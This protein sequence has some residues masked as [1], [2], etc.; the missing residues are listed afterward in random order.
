MLANLGLGVLIP[1]AS[2]KHPY[3]AEMLVRAAKS[4]GQYSPRSG[5][6]NLGG[7]GIGTS[8]GPAVESMPQ[9][10]VYPYISRGIIKKNGISW[11]G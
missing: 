4:F 8:R 11:R 9:S 1:M 7:E 5:M 2:T 6:E 10:G 3:P